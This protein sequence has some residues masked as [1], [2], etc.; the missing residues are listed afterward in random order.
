MMVT[1]AIFAL[2]MGW[3]VHARNILH[4]EDDFGYGIL[5]VECIG[6]TG[7]EIDRRCLSRRRQRWS[8]GSVKW[9]ISIALVVVGFGTLVCVFRR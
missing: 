1:V 4:E 6:V 2:V 8:G 7:D 3:A 5:F 9:S